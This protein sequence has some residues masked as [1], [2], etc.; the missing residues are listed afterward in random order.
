MHVTGTI[1]RAHAAKPNNILNQVT[2]GKRNAGLKLRFDGSV[3][4]SI[5]I[6]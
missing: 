6:V 3:F 1:N 2:L 5:V 4:I